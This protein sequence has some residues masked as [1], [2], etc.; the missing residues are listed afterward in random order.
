MT[1]TSRHNPRLTEVARLLHR[2][3]RRARQR[4]FVAEGED[5][6]AAADAAGWQPLERYCTAGSG[7]AGVE[8][9]PALLAQVCRLASGTRALAVYEQRWLP[10]PVGPLCVH[11]HGVRDPGNVGTI[12]RAARAFRASCVSLGPGSADPY[13]PRAVRASMGAIFAVGLARTDTVAQL[14]GVKVALAPRRGIALGDWRSVWPMTEQNASVSLVIGAERGGLGDEALAG[15]DIVAHI[16]ICG[17]SL[18]AA[19]AAAIALYE[20][21]A[22]GHLGL[23]WRDA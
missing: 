18:N 11:L 19:L 16:P 20:L 2:G 4:R 21:S 3:D 1:I 6:L 12:I 17:D 7:L 13:G 5:L 14:P 23:G 9:A 8:V 10:G 22:R 15:A